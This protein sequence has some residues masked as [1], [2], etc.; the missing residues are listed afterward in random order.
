MVY[1]TVHDKIAMD[2]GEAPV[3]FYKTVFNKYLE[4][5]KE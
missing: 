3:K 5:L 4:G 2:D 1:Q